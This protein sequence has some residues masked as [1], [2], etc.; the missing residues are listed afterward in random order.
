MSTQPK[1]P[2]RQI[3]PKDLVMAKELVDYFAQQQVTIHYAYARALIVACPAAIRDRYVHAGDAWTW[4]VL[5]PEFKPFT[6]RPVR[7]GVTRDLAEVA[8][9]S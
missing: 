1:Q 6:E 7:T 4:W 3:S 5:H 2:S 9:N 8:Q